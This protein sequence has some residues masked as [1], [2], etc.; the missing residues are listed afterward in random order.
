MQAVSMNA[1]SIRMLILW[2]LIAI[3][4]GAFGG[5]VDGTLGK[6]LTG[7]AVVPAL[8]V[9]SLFLAFGMPQKGWLIY[10]LPGFLAIMAYFTVSRATA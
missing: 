2:C 1:E 7:L 8:I 4:I 5:W 6:V 9:A 3:A 10:N